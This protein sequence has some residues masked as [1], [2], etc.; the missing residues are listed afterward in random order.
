MYHYKSASYLN[1]FTDEKGPPKNENNIVSRTD[2]GVKFKRNTVLKKLQCASQDQN[3]PAAAKS[4]GRRSVLAMAHSMHSS[5]SQLPNSQQI[6]HKTAQELKQSQQPFFVS[7]SVKEGSDKRWK[8][9]Q[10][11]EQKSVINSIINQSAKKHQKTQ[12]FKHEAD[13]FIK[14][15]ER[16]DFQETPFA[17]AR[18]VAMSPQADLR[19]SQKLDTVNKDFYMLTEA[20]RHEDQNQYEDPK[21]NRVRFNHARSLT[22]TAPVTDGA[23]TQ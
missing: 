13:L 22:S 5:Q 3:V 6:Y 20:G 12:S 7:T 19:N 17:N 10:S 2:K 11:K 9:L 1:G 14:S 15:Y 16:L 21:K 4:S 18:K 8:E 23:T